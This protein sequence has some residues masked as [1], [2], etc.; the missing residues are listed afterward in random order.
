MR[1]IVSLSLVASALISS[2]YGAD[3]LAGMFSEGKVSGQLREFSITRD[4]NGAS[5]F[6]RMANAVGGYVKYETGGWNGLSL[7]AALYGTAGF[8]LGNRSN[9]NDV[10]PTLLSKNNSNDIYFGEA[11]LQYK[12][13]NTAFKAGRQKLDTPMAGSDDARMLPNLFEAYVL[14]N[15]DIKDTTLVA[16]HVTK[17][18]QGTFGRVYNA[19]ANHANAVLSATAGYSYWDSRNQTG[20]F[21]DMGKYAVGQN[22]DGVTVA[23]VVYSGVPGLKLQ[24]WDYYAH[25][26]LNA[27]YAEANYALTMSNGMAPYFAAQWINERDVGSSYAGN[28]QSDF[29]GAKAGVKV[30][31][32]DLYAAVSSNTKDA[33]SPAVNGGTISPWGGM[34]AY[35]Q[36]MVTRHQFM[37]GTEAWKVAGNY[38]WK[39]MGVNLNTGVYY[40]SFDLDALNGYSAKA[41]TTTESG[42]DVIYSP[43]KMKNLQ[44]RLRANYTRDFAQTAAGVPTDWD[45]YRFITNY[46]F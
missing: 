40:A 46:N 21:V 34:P 20:S 44:L 15:T 23:A 7:G 41:C 42:F 38:N 14:S 1:R 29:F 26:I 43:E 27:V 17:F 6:T 36:G 12:N 31:N 4:Y 30:A 28:V 11:Y 5:N 45:E 8:E 3:D 2:A 39:D 19:S 32:F 13:G 22:T 24:L 37:A 9:V 33:S 35:T 10:D 16:A 25:D 18:A